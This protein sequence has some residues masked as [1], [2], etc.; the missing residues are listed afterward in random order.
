MSLLKEVTKPSYGFLSLKLLLAL[1]KK[2]NKPTPKVIE[3]PGTLK[4]DD[5][6]FSDARWDPF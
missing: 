3:L 4:G 6:R 1:N 2:I 5:S